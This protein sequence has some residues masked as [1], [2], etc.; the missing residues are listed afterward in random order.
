MNIVY[1][2]YEASFK[3]R[4]FYD[5]CMDYDKIDGDIQMLSMARTGLN[6]RTGDETPEQR[7]EVARAHAELD[8]IEAEMS[9]SFWQQTSSE[10]EIDEIDEIDA[11]AILIDIFDD[12]EAGD[13]EI[14]IE[15]Y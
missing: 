15:A 9:R 10:P 6:E 1:I 11:D 7:L 13:D 2:L 12:P 8:Q 4:D 14:E 3:Y 5:T